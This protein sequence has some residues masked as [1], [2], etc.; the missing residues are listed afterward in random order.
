MSGIPIPL[1]QAVDAMFQN[2]T[3]NPKTLKLLKMALGNVLKNPSEPKFRS[4]NSQKLI[5]KLAADGLAPLYILKH[6]GFVAGETH[7]TL[8]PTADLKHVQRSLAAVVS[9]ELGVEVDPNTLE[10]GL[11]T[12]SGG[13]SSSTSAAAAPRASGDVTAA[14]AAEE[15]KRFV[16][17]S[18][19]E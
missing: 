10:V 5:P 6:A 13:A 18:H 15:L 9:R 3:A 11:G 14:E 17:N 16:E 4:L 12:S 7:Y 2:G 19:S 8:A 1:E